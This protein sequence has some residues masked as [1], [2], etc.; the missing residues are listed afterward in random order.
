[1]NDILPLDALGDP[2]RRKLFE[3]LRGGPRSVGELVTDSGISQPAVSQHLSVLRAAGLVSSRKAGQRRIYAIDPAGLA[4]LR[5][6]IDSYWQAALQAF[7]AAAE[8]QAMEED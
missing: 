1:M 3:R 4:E 2:T 5:A 7:Q 6:Y 8:E